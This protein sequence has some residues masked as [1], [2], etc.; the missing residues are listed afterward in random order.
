[1]APTIWWNTRLSTNDDIYGTRVSQ[2]GI[3]LDINGIKIAETTGPQRNPQVAF[4]GG[5]YV[6]AWE[7]FKIV[8]GTEADIFAATVSTTGAVTQLGA[9]ANTATSETQPALAGRGTDAMLVWNANGDISGA[10][11]NGTSFGSPVAVAGTAALEVEPTVAANPAGEYLVAWS[12][13]GAATA[14]ARG[15]RVTSAGALSGAAFDISNAAGAQNQL[16]ASFTGT[17]FAVVWSDSDPGINLFG[18]RVSPAGVV[19]DTRVEATLTVGALPSAPLQTPKSSRVSR[20]FRP[21]A[22]WPGA[23]GAI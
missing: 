5:K 19:L 6:V 11:F 2:A 20:V 7:D 18:S 15:Q 17:D 12:E 16:A 13:G 22:L 1:M 4:A 21:D 8:G 23:I 9:V 3:V 10:V 14:D